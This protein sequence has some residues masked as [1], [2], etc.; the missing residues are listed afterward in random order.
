[1]NEPAKNLKVTAKTHR[2]AMLMDNRQIMNAESV[3]PALETKIHV[4][5]WKRPT[6]ART[7]TQPRSEERRVGKECPV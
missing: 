4:V 7:K 2:V 6:M 3:A 1:M 5:T